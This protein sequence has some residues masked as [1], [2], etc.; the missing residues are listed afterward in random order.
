MNGCN[1]DGSCKATEGCKNGVEANGACTCPGS[2][3]KGCNA[4]GSCKDPCENVVC[5]GDNEQCQNG[6]CV[7]LC[8]D[9]VCKNANEYCDMGNCRNEK[10]KNGN[11]LIDQYETAVNQGKACRKYSDCDS[12]VGKGD[13]FCDSFIG[14][15][16][17]TKC[18][19]D[20]Q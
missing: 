18:T 12:A 15:T 4:D 8:K 14:Y 1:A 7:D 17:S 9:V 20:A 5:K 16:C 6:A 3:V 19:S 13:G 10:D 11:H 2:C